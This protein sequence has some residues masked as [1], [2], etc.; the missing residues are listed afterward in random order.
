MSEQ[1]PPDNVIPILLPQ[2]GN[3][4]EEG[5]I[6]SWRFKVGDRIKAGDVLFDL[7]TDKATIEVES[8]VSGRLAKI[9]VGEGQSAP[10][11]T[12]VAYLSES[13]IALE[14]MVDAPPAAAEPAVVPPASVAQPASAAVS[15]R[16][17]A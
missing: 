12:P 11:K 17:K 2:A 1:T 5:T 7:E 14:R 10:V 6:L 16:R 15:S 13:D 3:S 9:V 4:M 8:E